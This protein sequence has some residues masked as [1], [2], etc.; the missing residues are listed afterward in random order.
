M[1]LI[2]GKG[3]QLGTAFGNLLG[4]EVEIVGIDRLDLVETE[5]IV[6][7][8]DQFQP[9]T[10]I[11]C[12]AATGVDAA[13]DDENEAYLVNAVAVE[14]MAGWAAKREIP[15]VT[16]S[17]DYVFSGTKQAPYVESDQPDPVNAYGASKLAGEQAALAAYPRS[18]VIRTS[19]LVS[20]THPNFL[21]TIIRKSREGP[22]KVVDDQ[23]GVPNVADDLAAAT[24]QVLDTGVVGTLHLSS[25]GEVTWC[26]FAR[27]ALGAA[28]MDPGLIEPAT[29]S[30]YQ[31]RA[32]RP[33]YGV[34][35][36][37]RA[38]GVVLPSWRDSLPDVVQ[39][40]LTWA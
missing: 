15:F 6:P 5:K 23:V 25:H 35:A 38:T 28:G 2:V 17:T 12:A 8:L 10:L 16:Y 34:L 9:E 40:I 22:L 26:A 4:S 14:A 39:G 11:N 31:T 32:A 13:E 21:S 7:T 24:M 19:W 1:H 18:L 37:E 27:E 30:E 33:G 29:S 20:R 36:S 3:G